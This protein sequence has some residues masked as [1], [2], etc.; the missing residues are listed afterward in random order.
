MTIQKAFFFYVTTALVTITT[1]LTGQS[2]G[3]T[4]I[5]WWHPVVASA[6]VAATFVVDQ[7]IRRFWQDNRS[8]TLDEVSDVAKSFKE[9]EVFYVAGPGV[10]A[11][12]LVL[13]NP[14]IAQTGLQVF[15]SY[16]L[17]SGLMIATKSLFGRSRPSTTPDD[18]FNFD[19]FGGGQNNAFPSGSAAIVFSLATTLSDAFDRTE[20]SVLLYSGAVLN[21]WSRV[22]GNRHWF[23]DVA[24]GGLYGVFAAKLVNGRWRIFGLRPPTV[25]IDPAGLTTLSFEFAI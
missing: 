9:S 8:G 2:R 21:S 20:V 14:H 25:I 6:G 15:T 18:E 11:L 12:G 7:P 24:L 1:P 10:M 19:W 22:Y 16:G 23:S 13:D 17:S 4:E 3:Y 5:K